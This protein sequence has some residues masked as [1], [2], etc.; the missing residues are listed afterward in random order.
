MNYSL[1]LRLWGCVVGLVA[2]AGTGSAA[3]S[4]TRAFAPP[5]A[6]ELKAAEAMK[7]EPMAYGAVVPQDV[8]AQVSALLG[9][10]QPVD[11]DPAIR[12][13]ALG[14]GIEPAFCL[15]R[16]EIRFEAYPGVLRG[17]KGAYATRAANA[18]D[19]ALLLARLLEAKGVRTR[20]ALGRLETS[21]TERL[22]ARM[23]ADPVR[24]TEAVEG[25]ENGKAARFAQ[26]V[27]AR[28][29]RDSAVVRNTLG[30]AM[31]V[32]DPADRD[33][34]RR[35][36]AAHVWVQASVNGKWI[37][38]DTAFAD[39]KPGVTYCAAERTVEELPDELYQRVTIRV[40]AERLAEGSL[41]LKTALEVR[42]PVVDLLERQIVL[43]HVPKKALG[44]GGVGGMGVQG[45][46][47]N[48]D[49]GKSWAP[50]LWSSGTLTAGEPIL[51][52]NRTSG[53]SG[54]GFGGMLGGGEGGESPD[55]FVAEYLEIETT[56]PGGP[57]ETVRRVLVDRGGPAW[58][59][60][61]PLKAERLA[62]LARGKSGPQAV[63][64]VHNLRLMAGQYDMAAYA[65]VVAA[66]MRRGGAER[67]AATGKEHDGAVLADRLRPFVV[68]G[69]GVALW[70]DQVFLPALNTNPRVRFYRDRPR[71]LLFSNAAIPGRNKDDPGTIES[72][73]DL[74]RDLVRGVAVDE[75][76]DAAVIEGKIWYGVLEGALE[77]EMGAVLVSALGGD[78]AAVRSTSSLCGRGGA[79]LLRPGD[80]ET[81][82]WPRLLPQPDARAAVKLALDGGQLLVV[83]R[84]IPPRDE[85]GWWAVAAT[86]DTRAVWGR[87]INAMRMAQGMATAT[88][89]GVSSFSQAAY[90]RLGFTPEK[91]MAEFEQESRKTVK[92]TSGGNEYLAVIKEILSKDISACSLISDEILFVV[93]QAVMEIYAI[94]RICP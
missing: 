57:T 9:A 40:L 39:A 20:F 13:G 2:A 52:A 25:T 21:D 70:G 50:V 81:K 35:E 38:L 93:N 58:R 88:R 75:S 69:L 54:A 33:R 66:L 4:A 64:T 73:I 89:S 79:A 23:F 11:F 59:K 29:L 44:G 26:Q 34:V 41:E 17:A 49:N 53:G 31:P 62:A 86:G 43:L 30:A 32:A 24:P 8:A 77:H 60:A 74:R 63:E 87:D 83:P 12:A 76:A 85:A 45:L 47:A 7:V 61:S 92:Q 5:D 10:N 15:V 71:V 82:E 51:F 14:A 90:E 19:R 80:G 3:P 94:Y 22:L 28:A 68:H 67:P 91:A 84:G 78:S 65:R 42:L 37:D 72:T 36:I 48:A 18:P 56:V 27:R 55:C 16:D 6:S 1:R 46:G